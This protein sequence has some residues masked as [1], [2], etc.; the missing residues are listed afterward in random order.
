MSAEPES[1][2]HRSHDAHEEPYLGPW[3]RFG[4]LRLALLAGFALGII[5]ALDQGDALGDTAAAVLYGMTAPGWPHLIG[6]AKHSSR[7]GS[8]GSISTS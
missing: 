7:C 4:P 1:S 5:F 3:W 6:A 2:D 8:A